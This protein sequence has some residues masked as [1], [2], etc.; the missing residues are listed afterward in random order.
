MEIKSAKDAFETTEEVIVAAEELRTRL[1]RLKGQDYMDPD[2]LDDLIKQVEADKA[3]YRDKILN[4][5]Q[6]KISVGEV[7]RIKRSNGVSVQTTTYFRLVMLGGGFKSQVDTLEITK[8]AYISSIV[9][10]SF[11]S[12]DTPMLL[13]KIEDPSFEKG[14]D[15]E[16]EYKANLKLLNLLP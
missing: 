4:R 14:E 10:K 2:V 3:K 11:V 6:E 7:C 13:L 9:Y 8:G 12:V 5:I 16:S 1:I 15:V